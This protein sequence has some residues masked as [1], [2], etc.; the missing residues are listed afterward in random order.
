MT[1]P[2]FTSKKPS[3]SIRAYYNAATKRQNKTMHF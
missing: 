3:V 1:L 2:N